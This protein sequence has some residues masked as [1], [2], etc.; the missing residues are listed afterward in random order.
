ML[1]S[2]PLQGKNVLEPLKGIAHAQSL[3]FNIIEL[4]EHTNKVEVHKF[5]NDL[6]FCLEGEVRF[7]C[8]G[9]MQESHTRVRSDGTLDKTEMRAKSLDGAQETIV[10]LGDWFWI[11]AGTPHQHITEKTARLM[12]IKIP[13]Q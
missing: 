3:A 5:L 4:A 12:I 2:N 1:G 11:P 9:R 6:W 10:R 13:Q 8:G 7:L